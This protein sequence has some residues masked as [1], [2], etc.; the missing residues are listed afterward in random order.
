MS[1]A[2]VE[3]TIGR[4]LG[5]LT[6]RGVLASSVL[7]TARVLR[8]LFMSTL[9]QPMPSL[10]PDQARYLAD[11]LATGSARTPGDPW[12]VALAATTAC[13]PAC[14]CAGV[15]RWAAFPK[16]PWMKASRTTP[17][18]SVKESHHGR[19]T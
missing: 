4:Y 6:A 3:H 1:A 7:T 18:P 15:P 11:A 9:G 17:R 14:S 10:Y 13:Q 19:R 5:S 12:P 2:T 16:T 8:S